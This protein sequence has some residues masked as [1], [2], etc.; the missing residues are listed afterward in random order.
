MPPFGPSVP[1]EAGDEYGLVECLALNR[2]D[3]DEDDSVDG[4]RAARLIEPS[5]QIRCRR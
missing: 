5:R 1:G 2:I 4:H 3:L